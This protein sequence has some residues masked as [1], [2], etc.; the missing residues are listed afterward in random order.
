LFDEK[1]RQTVEDYQIRNMLEVNGKI[2]PLLAMNIIADCIG[3]CTGDTDKGIE[4][5]EAEQEKLEEE[6]KFLNFDENE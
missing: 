6:N 3:G 2:T 4:E 1:T 5:W